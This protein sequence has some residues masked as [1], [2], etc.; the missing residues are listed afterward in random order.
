[1][2]KEKTY[3]KVCNQ[4]RQKKIMTAFSKNQFGKDNR[5]LR[6]PVCKECYKKKSTINP[7]DRREY[8]KN[9]Q[10]L[11]LEKVGCALFVKWIK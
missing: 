3:Y 1:M 6:R 11:K 8:Q 5:I 4:C 9:I 2:T 10:D 7:K